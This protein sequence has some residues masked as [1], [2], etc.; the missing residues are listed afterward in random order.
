VDVL[1]DEVVLGH[2]RPRVRLVL[3]HDDRLAADRERGEPGHHV[4]LAAGL[5]G[6]LAGLVDR[7]RR[8]VV[9]Q[10]HDWLVTSRSV[11]SEYFARATSCWVAPVAAEHDLVR[12][13]LERHRL[14]DLLRVV[15][16]TGL[17]PP[18][19]R[20]VQVVALLD[21][22]PA[23]VLD[24]PEGLGDQQAL[25]GDG[26]V[27][28]AGGLGA[29]DAVVVAGRVVPEQGQHEPVLAPGRPVAPAAVAVGLEEHGHHVEP[30]A[31]RPLG[32]G[33]LDRQRERDGLAVVLDD[34]LPNPVA[35]RAESAALDLGQLRVGDGDLG[36][37]RH[38]GCHAVGPG[39]LDD[40]VL[41]VLRGLQG[42]VG[43]EHLE[44]R[45]RHN[46]R[47]LHGGG[48]HVIGRP[49]GDEQPAGDGRASGRQ[50]EEPGKSF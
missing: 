25:L 44:R 9:A 15:R 3:R 7:G 14:G 46:L 26:E 5:G 30:K 11:P 29:G 27:D 41:V 39:D 34:D 10:E 18:E 38:V 35:E 13:Q 21:E 24:G 22:L 47:G 28:P 36:R 8:V 31:D 45:C 6:H 12:V 19:H 48:G 17:Q 43:R 23:G 20:P 2:V 33:V 4:R 16:G 50:S 37:G 32:L 1:V 42:D 49:G 40:E